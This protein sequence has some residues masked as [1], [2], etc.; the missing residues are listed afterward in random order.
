M[1]NSEITKNEYFREKGRKEKLENGIQEF[2]L[3][4]KQSNNVRLSVKSGY[5][6]TD[7]KIYS[8]IGKK[9]IPL[10]RKF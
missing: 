7:D 6:L 1:A 2:I 4:F 9:P 10:A 8:Q 5:K 3:E